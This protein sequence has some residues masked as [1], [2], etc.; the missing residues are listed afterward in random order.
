MNARLARMRKRVMQMHADMETA[1]PAEV[2]EQDRRWAEAARRGAIFFY[3]KEEVTIGFRKVDWAGTHIAHQEWPAQLNRFFCLPRLAAV[4][5][6]EQDE[7]LARIAHD[8]IADWMDAHAY[9][10]DTPPGKGDNTLNLAIRMGQCMGWGWWMN[11]PF[12]AASKHFDDAFLDRMVASSEGQLACLK[13][14]LARSSNWRISHLDA[15]LVCGL[16]VPALAP[17]RDYAVRHLNET[18]H[19]QVHADGAHEEH[20]PSYHTWMCEVFTRYW[21]LAQA[22]PKLGLCVD[23]QRLARMWDYR[24]QAT[25]PDGGSF[26]IHD[27]PCWQSGGKGLHDLRRNYAEVRRKAVT[28]AGGAASPPRQQHFADAGQVFWRSGWGRD[29]TMVMFDATRWGGGHCHLSRLAVNLFHGGR[30]LLHDPGYFTYEMSDPF[31]PYG[32]T[33]GAHN[34]ATVHGHSQTE[35][36]PVVKEVFLHPDFMVV[37][38]RYEGGYYPGRYTWFW[39]E[40]KGQGVFG[41]HVRTLLWLAGRGGLVW[42]ELYFQQAGRDVELRWQLPAGGMSL[43]PGRRQAATRDPGGNVL[44]RSL[45]ANEPLTLTALEG[46]R[47]PLGG[48]LPGQ[49]PGQYGP[50]PQ[51]VFRRRLDGWHLATATLLVP[52]TGEDLP[53][54]TA[55]PVTCAHGKGWAWRV[56]W[57]S[58][59]EDVIAASPG[60]HTQIDHAGGL[61]TDA[62]LAVWRRDPGTRQRLLMV[63]GM[64]A[65]IEGRTVVRKGSAGNWLAPL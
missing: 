18:F 39:P 50:A 12:F 64:Y 8:W 15:M 37:S 34:T 41:V 43:D 48:W 20:N 59:G 23:P 17:Y 10:A 21:Q 56:S 30:M 55:E 54:V 42:D 40:G 7:E 29:A 1:V 5:R 25:A 27:A 22:R 24:L 4:Y 28:G 32:K 52:F 60:L 44:V 16:L 6:A 38:A 61:D 49:A 53:P 62:A 26:G 19:R 46:S 51:L 11:V 13:A 35:A 31:G 2:T 9:R 33:T 36:D 45:W 65:M 63:N 47:D 3:E 57:P 58:G 14:H